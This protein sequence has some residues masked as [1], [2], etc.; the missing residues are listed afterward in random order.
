MT[1]SD[2]LQA[3]GDLRGDVEH[4]DDYPRLLQ[5]TAAFYELKPALLDRKF[6]EAHGDPLVVFSRKHET[7][8]RERHLRD[9]AK[10]RLQSLQAAGEVFHPS[11]FDRAGEKT[12]WKSRDF[13]LIGYRTSDEPGLLFVPDDGSETVFVEHDM[14]LW[15]G[16]GVLSP[17]LRNR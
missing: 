11:L 16:L 17:P 8:V 1:T 13:Y 6:R 5:E 9:E 4:P 7:L 15:M 12:A 3:I 10:R 2:L 14:V